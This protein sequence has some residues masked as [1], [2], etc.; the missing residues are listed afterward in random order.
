MSWSWND[1]SSKSFSV[2]S[3]K[4]D[5]ER[6]RDG[7]SNDGGNTWNWGNW[8]P[9]ASSYNWGNWYNVTYSGPTLS[10]SSFSISGSTVKPTSNNTGSSSRTGTITVSNSGDSATLSLSQGINRDYDYRIRVSSNSYNFS[11]G[12]GS[13][14][15]TVY[16]EERTGTGNPVVWGSWTAS[17]TGSYDL[18]TSSLPSGISA[19]KSGNTVTVTATANSS[20]SSGRS[21]SF[22]VT[23]Y[24]T[25]YSGS[26]PSASVSITQDRKVSVETREVRKYFFSVSPSLLDFTSDGGSKSVTVT[27]YYQTATQT[28]TDNGPWLPASPTFSGKT[29]VTPS[30]GS[31]S[32][33]AFSV[34]SVS[35]SSG[36]YTV[37]VTASSN[38]STS[39][40]SGSFDI[41]QSRSGNYSDFT[42]DDSNINVPLNQ[43]GKILNLGT[44]N[45]GWKWFNIDIEEYIHLFIII[46]NE[47]DGIQSE[48]ITPITN[49]NGSSGYSSTHTLRVGT[50]RIID[51]GSVESPNKY[52][53]TNINSTF[54]IFKD[55]ET[56]INIRTEKVL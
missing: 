12:G 51:G 46:K 28:S 8:V 50:Y 41:S 39:N 29:G 44:L 20:T 3:Q 47:D 27:S 43:S 24:N 45:I 5:G 10:G 11:S 55:K 53:I 30:A 9:S 7:T 49:E 54:T 35:G 23:H 31:S 2:S 48:I 40:R 22:T 17:S 25:A 15:I 38:S 16:P 19:F 33:S 21:G 18:S 52:I 36:T 26:R 56:T 1:T 14:T 34:G 32:N 6:H 37:N 4:R 42:S 13:T